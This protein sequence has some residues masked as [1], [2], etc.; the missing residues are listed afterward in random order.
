MWHQS[1][2]SV[3][4]K[5]MA[6]HAA[7]RPSPG[8][9][10]VTRP[11]ARSQ[12]RTGVAS[13]VTAGHPGFARGREIGPRPHH[14]L[15]HRRCSCRRRSRR[16]PAGAC[17]A[18]RAARRRRCRPRRR[19][20]T[21]ACPET[22]RA[23]AAGSARTPSPAARPPT[24]SAAREPGTGARR[25][26]RGRRNAAVGH[27]AVVERHAAHP[28]AGRRDHLPWSRHLPI[29]RQDGP[30]HSATR[31]CGRSSVPVH[32]Q[33]VNSRSPDVGRRRTTRSG[34]ALGRRRRRCPAPNSPRDGAWPA[35][36]RER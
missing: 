13:A 3:G 6:D 35:P 23:A 24:A 17:P 27:D 25:S 31:Q 34:P 28:A 9:G 8:P 33:R 22:V 32:P 12:I 4:G 36:R 5:S 15:G 10:S 7:R 1:C 11:S 29:V 2:S 16:A 18:A 19:A 20:S 21:P 14:P 26:G 30:A